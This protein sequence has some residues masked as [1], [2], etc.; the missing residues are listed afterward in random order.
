MFKFKGQRSKVKVINGICG[1]YAVVEVGRN[2]EELSFVAPKNFFRPF[3]GHRC[4]NFCQNAVLQ[5]FRA[6]KIESNSV[7]SLSYALE[8]LLRSSSG[9]AVEW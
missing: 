5:G 8:S 3:L 1:V 6:E 9:T 4:T 2:S 7:F